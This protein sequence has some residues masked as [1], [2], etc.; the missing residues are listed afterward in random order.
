MSVN[1]AVLAVG[2]GRRAFLP[3]SGPFWESAIECVKFMVPQR[4]QSGK[5]VSPLSTRTKPSIW[6]CIPFGMSSMRRFPRCSFG[7]HQAMSLH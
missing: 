4:S 7:L 2:M 3:E 6:H 1:V 5:V